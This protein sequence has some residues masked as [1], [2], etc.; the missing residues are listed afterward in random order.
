MVLDPA[1]GVERS[2]HCVTISKPDVWVWPKGSWYKLL[3]VHV[4]AP[5]LLGNVGYFLIRMD[6]KVGEI[7]ATMEWVKTSQRNTSPWVAR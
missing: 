5:H 7:G 4:Y 6:A 3:K 2:N 1:M